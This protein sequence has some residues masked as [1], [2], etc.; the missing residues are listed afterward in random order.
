M[1]K[2][3]L[4]VQSNTLVE[5]KYR[6]SV[7]EQKIIKILIS[8]IQREDEDFK[9]Y[10]FHIRELAKMLG[11]EHKDPYRVLEKITER[12]MSRVLKFSSSETNTLLQVSWLSSTIYKKGE[13]TVILRFDPNLKP[14]LLQLQSYFTK[15][16]LGQVLQF[17]GQYTIRFFEFR[18]SF[19]GKNKKVVEFPLNKLREAFG[20]G[21]NEYQEFDN[22]RRRVIE[23][24]RIELLEKTGQS[25]V[26]E[27]IRQGRGGKVVG[28]RFVFDGETENEVVAVSES[29]PKTENQKMEETNELVSVPTV[30]PESFKQTLSEGAQLLI[31]NGISESVAVSL[32]EKYG[33]PYLREKIALANLHPDY[34]KNKAGFL[35]Q[36]IKENWVDAD[37]V[38]NQQK[39]I[40]ANAEKRREE[41]RKQVKGIWDR[42]RVQRYALGLKKYEKMASEEIQKLKDEFLAGLKDI[43][44]NVYRKK[45]NFGYEDGM[46]QSFF[47]NTLELPSFENFLVAE[48]I[49]LSGEERE[50]LE[51]EVMR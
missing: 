45:E 4:V 2:K 16:E 46:F 37:I 31:E 5:A 40:A 36:A 17:K 13:G 20:L 8:Q 19:L 9:A 26:W 38:R 12:L 3:S 29:T 35:I 1:N 27:A 50:I 25:F 7:E 41:T 11:M 6:L 23:P 43:F 28:I 51:R 48:G 24:A 21:K 33:I 34:I 44:R 10:E 14:L 22:F 15:Y 18:K 32:G 30:E 49:T 47:L 42:Y 39:N